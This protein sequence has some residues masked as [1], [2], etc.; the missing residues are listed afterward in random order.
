MDSFF[1]VLYANTSSLIGPDKVF[2]NPSKKGRFQVRLYCN[3]LWGF[4]GLYSLGRAFWMAKVPR[5]VV[6][7][8]WTAALGKI[9]TVDNLHKRHILIV[10]WCCVCKRKGAGR[11]SIT[12]SSIVPWLQIFDLLYL[13]YVG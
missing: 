7:F 6:F 8:V 5:K 1:E 12:C 4:S 11:L 9:L 10:D 13:N 3:V 2:W